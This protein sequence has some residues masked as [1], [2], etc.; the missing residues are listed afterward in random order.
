MLQNIIV[1]IY[2]FIDFVL[3][4][5]IYFYLY[6]KLSVTVEKTIVRINVIAIT[7]FYSSPC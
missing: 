4:L 7:R 5:F 6:L 1:C 3:Y 2:I